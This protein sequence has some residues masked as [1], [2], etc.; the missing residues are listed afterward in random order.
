MGHLPRAPSQEIRILTINVWSGLTYKGFFKMG[1]YE[2]HPKKRY[3][4]LLSEV[5]KLAPDIIAIQEA[6]PLPD[7]VK[8]LAADLDYQVIYCVT[9]EGIRFGSFGIPTNM[10]EGQ[11]ILVKRPWTITEL[12]RK[13]LSGGGIVTNWFSFHFH[14]VTQTLLGRAV[15]N[16]KPLY[17]YNVHLHERPV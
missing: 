17:I 9:L 8:Q 4:L 16:G 10:R 2:H 12:G 11:A 1:E 3:E 15:I 14:E 13:R 7:Y 5:R 6:N